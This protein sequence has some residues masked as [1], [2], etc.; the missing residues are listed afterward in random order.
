MVTNNKSTGK[1]RLGAVQICSTDDVSRNLE[2]IETVLAKNPPQAGDLILLP[3][4][5][6]CLS[7]A[8]NYRRLAENVG[9]GPI[10]KWLSQLAANYQITLVGGSLPTRM[11]GEKR[12]RTT[13][14]AYDANGQYCAHYHK[15]HLF[16]VDLPGDNQY[17]ESAKFIAGTKPKWFI[18]QKIRIGMSICFD[19]R[20]PYLYQWLKNHGC[21]VLLVPAAFTAMTGRAHWLPLLQARAIEQQCYVIA[22]GQSG[23]H[24]EH[25]YTWGHS[26]IIDPWGR[27]VSQLDEQQGICYGEFDGQLVRSLRQQMP[28]TANPHMT[29]SWSK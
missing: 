20:F 6:A 14:L 10:Q 15:M 2:Q 17:C 1:W 18:H 5:F 9:E 24:D 22:A 16:D 7:V 3:E 11:T 13:S 12:C 8:D 23:Q 28:L 21:T 19:L 29:I 25:R 27:V 4:N 26:C